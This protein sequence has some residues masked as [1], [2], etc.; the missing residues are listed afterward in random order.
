MGAIN[1]KLHQ[2]FGFLSLLSVKPFP[3]APR[4]MRHETILELSLFFVR[5]IRARD[6]IIRKRAYLC[7]KYA[8]PTL[9]EVVI[10]DL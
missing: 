1:G 5:I 9:S 2:M 8:F 3:C 7:N 6:R 10:R 4:P